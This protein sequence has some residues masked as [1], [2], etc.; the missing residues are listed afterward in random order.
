M[1]TLRKITHG[2]NTTAPPTVPGP[3]RKPKATAFET[4]KR[5]FSKRQSKRLTRLSGKPKLERESLTPDSDAGFVCDV[6]HEGRLVM[7][8]KLGKKVDHVYYLI[9]SPTSQFL[10]EFHERRKTTNLN[11]G[12]WQVNTNGDLQRTLRMTVA[13][14]ANIGPKSAQVTERQ[15]QR[16]ASIPGSGYAIDIISQNEGI[17]YSDVFNISI[18][19]CL[20]SIGE[21]ETEIQVFANVNFL[22]ST[23]AVVKTFISKNSYDGLE[24]FF[25][26]LKQQLELTQLSPTK[27][28]TKPEILYHPKKVVCFKIKWNHGIMKNW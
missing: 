5:A 15:I 21:N 13:I 2:T 7:K 22:K 11:L 19:Y 16:K 9:F 3:G 25:H 14:V 10:R 17:P 27:W 18:H 28:L 6:R 4:I 1:N 12:T 8:G 23:W 20:R 24:E 26:D